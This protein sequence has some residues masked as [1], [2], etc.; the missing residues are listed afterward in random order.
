[1]MKIPQE[2]PLQIY[3]NVTIV[4]DLYVHNIKVDKIA[5]LLVKDTPVNV[6]D[7]FNSFWTKSTDQ[8]ITGETIFE[9]GLTIDKLNIKYLNGF[10]ASD[11]LYTTVKEIP[12]E[13]TN[14]Y[15]Q[16][17]HV[18]EFLSESDN[19]SLFQVQSHGLIIQK[20]VYL[21]S[22]ESNDIIT[23]AFNGIDVDDIMNG[24]GVN[25][26]RIADFPVVRA[27]RV[28]VDKLDVNLLNDREILFEEGLHID[29]EH[30]L[31]LLKTP[32][33]HVRNLTVGRLNDINMNSF[34]RLNDLVQPEVSRVVID[35]DLTVED[36][37]L[38][39]V[40]KEPVTSFLDKLATHDVMI[41]TEKSIKKLVVRNITL[42][43]L[44]GQNLNNFFA[45][46]LSKS[47][48]Q[49]ISGHFSAH[50]VHSDNVAVDF[51]NGQNTTELMW[52]NNPI[53]INGDVT[54]TNLFV[55]GD[56]IASKM[57]G[58]EV[59]EVKMKILFT[60]FCLFHFYQMPID[61]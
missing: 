37:R 9:R 27:N 55:E 10:E 48:N 1:M 44:H 59:N 30:Q 24:I 41:T 42:E 20:E 17:F 53:T 14:L 22:L 11:F 50:I 12:N 43:S 32:E 35:G 36:L 4:G 21:P 47:Q 54:F 38:I 58:H 49:M 46:V 40:D 28:V 13:F 26:S 19:L 18:D 33:F 31:L 56:V 39:Q 60:S 29:D 8:T 2:R 34:T 45:S 23:L 5:T 57:N 6:S 15:F 7:M 25:T 51:I 16:N 3:E 61:E 52:V